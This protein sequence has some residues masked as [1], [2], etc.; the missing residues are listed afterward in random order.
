MATHDATRRGGLPP[1][2]VRPGLAVSA[3]VVTVLLGALTLPATVP[4]RPGFAYFCG[5]LIGAVLLVGILM[6]ADLVRARAARRAGLSVVGITLGAFGSRLAVAPPAPAPQL[7]AAHPAGVRGV[8]GR[9]SLG[10]GVDLVSPTGADLPAGTRPWGP[11]D[12]I[13]IEARL[14]RAGLAVTALAGAVLM[15]LGALAPSGTLALA[16]QVALWVGTFALLVTV[17][18]ALPSPRSAGGRLIAARVLRRTGSRER[19]ERAVSRAGVAT[20]WA[21]II[22]GAVGV[23]VVGFVA[24]WAALLGWLALGTSRLAQSQQRTE[25]ALAGLVA[26]DV[27]TPAPP[28]LSSWSTVDDALDEVV[29]PAHR[30]VFGVVDFDGALAGIA[31]LR[32]LAAVPMDDRDLVRVNR[33]V[34]PLSMVATAE[35]TDPLADLPARLIERPAAGCVIVVDR[36]DAGGS[37]MIG[38][39]GPAELSQAIETAPLRGRAAGALRPGNIWR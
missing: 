4:D 25:A 31:L 23:F 37:R 5:G 13:R 36:T 18:D 27:M 28:T 24:L 22:A 2:T 29:L 6:G 15:T 20:G 19:A 32:D 3:T 12:A 33:V 1:I 9:D 35:A 16:A 11:E 8:G 14:A 38:T 39:V 34:V 30:A 21:L 17:V 10:I 26:R 7:A